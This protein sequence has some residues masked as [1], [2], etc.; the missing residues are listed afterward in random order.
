M[1]RLTDVQTTTNKKS[2]NKIKSIVFFISGLGLIA[3]GIR[4]ITKAGDLPL[5][6]VAIVGGLALFKAS[7]VESNTSQRTSRR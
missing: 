1:E 4:L 2:E 3:G 6:I 7:G 5:G